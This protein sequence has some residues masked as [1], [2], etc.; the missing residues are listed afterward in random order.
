MSTD[1]PTE[2]TR[3]A[4]V[5]RA[6]RARTGGSRR[7]WPSTNRWPEPARCATQQR[8]Q[9][10]DDRG[11]ADH[12]GGRRPGSVVDE[13]EHGLDVP[14]HER[15][16]GR[17]GATDRPRHAGQQQAGQPDGRSRVEEERERSR[18]GRGRLH[19]GDGGRD[20]C[21]RGAEPAQAEH[22]D[23]EGGGLGPPAGVAAP[24]CPGSATA[25]RYPS[26]AT[27]STTS[28]AGRTRWPAASGRPARPSPISVTMSHAGMASN[29]QGTSAPSTDDATRPATAAMAP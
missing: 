2:A 12:P 13:P 22:G 7:W 4:A 10:C 21:D 3:G 29:H 17:A 6:V 14:G 11:D 5:R 1:W 16:A 27:T 18:P 20:G 9:Q 24:T 23:D 26:S 8:G 28:T 25:N 15:W 19:R